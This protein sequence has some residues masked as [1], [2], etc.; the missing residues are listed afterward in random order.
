MLLLFSMKSD[1]CPVRERSEKEWSN[2]I[3]VRHLCFKALTLRMLYDRLGWERKL[4]YLVHLRLG[5]SALP[6]SNILLKVV[7]VKSIMYQV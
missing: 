1:C 7:V 6:T 4:L 3:Q 5:K 2:R